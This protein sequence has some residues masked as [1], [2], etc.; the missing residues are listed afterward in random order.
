MAKG[1]RSVFGFLAGLAQSLA[2]FIARIVLCLSFF[3]LGWAALAG[4]SQFSSADTAILRDQLHVDTDV[5][6]DGTSTGESYLELALL[7]RERHIGQEVVAARLIAGIQLVGG[8]LILLGFLSRLVSLAFLVMLGVLYLP[9]DISPEA[10]R[11][12]AQFAD[13][14]RLGAIA[15]LSAA[16][17]CLLVL[18]QGPGFLSADAVL[19]GGRHGGRDDDDAL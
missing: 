18:A 12:M 8:A 15:H 16:A 11:T 1:E 17:L 4:S 2:P 10:L 14:A 13:T 3:P 6:E 5:S 19:F 9:T 7:L